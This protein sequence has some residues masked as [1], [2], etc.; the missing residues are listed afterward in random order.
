MGASHHCGPYVCFISSGGSLE[1]RIYTGEKG[2]R[3]GGKGGWEV[4]GGIAALYRRRRE[5]EEA[6]RATGDERRADT[7][8]EG[9]GEGEGVKVSYRVRVGER[10]TERQ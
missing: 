8:T 1:A 3:R 10:D 2:K 4:A 7:K 6:K 9:K 5:E